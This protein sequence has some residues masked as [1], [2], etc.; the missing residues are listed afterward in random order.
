MDLRKILAAG[1]SIAMLAGVSVCAYADETDEAAE[2]DAEITEVAEDEDADGTLENSSSA[3]IRGYAVIDTSTSTVYCVELSWNV[4][5]LK[6][7]QT[8]V[9]AWDTDSLKYAVSDSDST[10]EVTGGA[11]GITLDNRSNA[12][13]EATV[14]YSDKDDSISTTVEWVTG[15]TTDDEGGT[16]DTTS[17]EDQSV[18]LETAAQ[19]SGKVIDY[20]DVSTTGTVVEESISGTVTVTDGEENLTE[21]TTVVGTVTITLSKSDDTSTDYTASSSDA[22]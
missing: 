14:A 6:Y 3:E 12:A 7:T 21:A 19:N 11:I 10:A 13:V 4:E 8:S 17:T 22:E 2:P 9:Y 5:D 1:L 18:V 20:T 16:V 15:T